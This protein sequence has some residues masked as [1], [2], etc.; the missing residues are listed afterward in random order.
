MND[1]NIIVNGN[2]NTGATGET[3]TSE[4]AHGNRMTV[5]NQVLIQV[6]SSKY[7]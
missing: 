4:A 5:R 1:E 3:Q 2:E 7:R 6:N